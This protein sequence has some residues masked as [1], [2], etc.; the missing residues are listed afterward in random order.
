MKWEYASVTV[1]QRGATSKDVI[2]AFTRLGQEDFELVAIVGEVAYFKRA[3]VIA[4]AAAIQV[5]T[6]APTPS[7]P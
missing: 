1:P 6:S 2:E 7:T 5:T 4:A 3:K